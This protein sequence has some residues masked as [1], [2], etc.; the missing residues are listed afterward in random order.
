MN[1]RRIAI[2][3][4]LAGMIAAT[5]CSSG[6]PETNQGNR[7]GQRVVDSVN[8][9]IDTYST[10]RGTNTN[11]DLDGRRTNG[12]V[13]T[14]D[15][16]IVS[17][18]RDGD[19]NSVI[20]RA[21]RGV[22]R[23][24]RGIGDT[25]RDLNL[26]RPQGRIGNAFR[27]GTTNPGNI[28]NLD[29]TERA[30]TE[31]PK[32]TAVTR[33]KS[34]NK[35]TANVNTTRNTNPNTS[36]TQENKIVST[37]E[38]QDLQPEVKPNTFRRLRSTENTIRSGNTSRNRQLTPAVSNGIGILPLS[39]QTVPVITQT[40]NETNVTNETNKTALNR[41]ERRALRRNNNNQNTKPEAAPSVTPVAPAK[42]ASSPSTNPTSTNPDT[43]YEDD[44]D[45]DYESDNDVD[46]DTSNTNQ[47]NQPSE[48]TM[49]PIPKASSKTTK[50]A[51][52]PPTQP[53]QTPNP[54]PSQK[55]PMRPS[56]ARL[57]K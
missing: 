41:A 20:R 56:T 33:A 32:R 25:A 14:Y 54:A 22:N 13:G 43:S 6:L 49:K 31:A 24:A 47:P 26:G 55:I 48:K 5:G 3:G 29:S 19:G 16:G 57:M 46:N 18:E 39:E 27:Y 28:Q 2:T 42:P 15:N 8:G 30:A 40:T 9:R 37:P 45:F 1:W 21:T 12:L 17:G 38:I 10:T 34:A 36:I 50:P 23:A 52:Q 4:T 51:P 35:S 11:R 7:N 44:Q 53:E